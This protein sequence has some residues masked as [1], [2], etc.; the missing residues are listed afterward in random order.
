[1]TVDAD[2]LAERIAA[3]VDTYVD[4]VG[5]GTPEQ[6]ADL[7]APGATVEDPIGTEVRSTR[8]QLIEFYAVIAAMDERS[9]TL[10]W[11][12][13]AGDTAV[14]EFTLLTKTGGMGFE[15]TPVDIM[16][17]DADGK[18]ASMRAVWRSDDLKQV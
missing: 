17:F 9:T 14:F 11:R 6:I 2:V 7:Y 4:L 1:M 10:R 13:I 16:V 15:I 8:E 18:I 3:T 12:K 5:G